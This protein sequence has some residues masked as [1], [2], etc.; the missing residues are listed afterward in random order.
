M[1]KV[2]YGPLMLLG[3]IQRAKRTQA[4]PLMRLGIYFP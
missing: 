2:L 1:L 4:L 3:L